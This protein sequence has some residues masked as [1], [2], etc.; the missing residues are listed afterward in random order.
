[1]NAAEMY[2]GWLERA[3]QYSSK[4]TS[5]DNNNKSTSKDNN[6]N[7]VVTVVAVMLLLPITL[8]FRGVVVV[9]T[10]PVQLLGT[11]TISGQLDDP[12]PLG[13]ILTNVLYSNYQ[14]TIIQR[15][16]SHNL[17]M[18]KCVVLSIEVYCFTI[19]L[20]EGFTLDWLFLDSCRD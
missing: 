1:M 16:L 19:M 10:F 11:V 12:I 13:S 8:T 17:I 4:S 3:D 6:N 2:V 14:L 5:K 20:R 18:S 7:C 15:A 9:G